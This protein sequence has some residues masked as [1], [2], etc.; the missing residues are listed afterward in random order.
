M[1]ENFNAPSIESL[2]SIFNRLQKIISQLVIL[3]EN[4]SQEYLNMKSLRSLPSEWNTHVIVWRNKTDLDIMSIDDL[5]NNFKIVKQE[6]KRTVVSSSSSGSL[7]MAFL[8]S[9]SSTNEV[10]TASIQVSGVSTP[11]SIV[12]LEQIHEDDLEVMDLKWQLTLLSMRARRSFQ[13]TGKEIIINGSD[14]AGYDKTKV[15]CF[16]CH[17]MGHFAREC[18]SPR[19]QES[20]PGNQDNL[21]KTVNVEDTSSKAMVAIDGA[22]FNKFEFD[23]ATYKR[24]LASVEEQLAFYKKN[25]VVF[26]DQIDVLKRD[27]SFRD[28]EITVLNLQKEKLKNEKESN[29][30]KINNFKNASKSLDKLIG[31]QITDNSRTELGFTSYTIVAP[32]PT[33][34][35]AP[36]SIYLSNSGLEEFQHPE[37]KGYGPKDSK[38]VYVD[39]SNE[40]KKVPDAPIIKDWNFAPTAVLTKSG[41]VPISTARQS[42]S[43]TAAP[44]SDARPINT[45]ASKHLGN[46]APQDALKDQGYFDSGCSRH[47]TV[48]KDETSRILKG[49]ITDIE[50]QVEKT[51]QQNGV[52][53]RRN[54]TQIEAPRTMLA[55][56]KLPTTF[57]AEAVNTA[58]YVQNR[59]L[60]VKPHFKTPYELFKGRSPALSFMRPFEC[61][62]S[63]LNTLDQLGKFDG[64][65]DEGI[66]VGYSTT[67]KAFR[68]YIIRTIKVEE[69]L[70]ITFLENKP[71]IAGGG[72]EWL[73]D[74]DALSKS[75]NYAPVSA[76]TNYNDFSASD[77]HNKDKHGSS[78]ASK[79]DN[80]ERPNDESSTKTVNTAGPVNN[81]TP[82]YVDY[83]NDHLMPDLE[84]ARIFDDAYDDRDE[85]KKDNYNNLE[86][87]ISVSPIPSTR[88]HKDHPKEHIIEE[89]SQIKCTRWKKLY[90]V[91]IKLLE[92][93]MRLYPPTYWIM[94]SKE[95][96]LADQQKDGIFLSREKY[97]SDILKKFSFSSIKSAS[98]PMETHKPLS[99]D[100]AGTDVDVHLYR[101]MIGLLMYLTS[102]R[103]D[104]MFA[105]PKDLPLELIAYSDSDYAGAS[106]DRKSTTGGLKLKGYLINDGYADLVQHADKKELAIPGQTITGKELSN[107]LMAGSLPKTN[108]QLCWKK[109][110][111]TEASIRHDLKLNDAECT[112]CLLVKDIKER[113]KNQ[114]QNQ[115]KSRANE[116]Y[117][118]V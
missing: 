72:P 115:K 38:S 48:T 12:N 54:R 11:V 2:D 71:M 45:A 114:S 84:H 101:S 78:Q 66:F 26:C 24:G 30:I 97:V 32:P 33:G 113:D 83:L 73:F 40:I 104:I 75:M 39:T 86:T 44:V 90:M 85:S 95:G 34:L 21:R 89:S 37:F 111:I 50:N 28:L 35:F 16:N 1:Y 112:S 55:D 43:C 53:E 70:H 8:S 20:R 106:L 110:V 116:K 118:K 107:L 96:E 62:I 74:I 47:M 76:G 29:Q 91:F 60:V 15:E 4:I 56:S 103:P 99:K 5:Y 88:I 80:Q 27:A 59:V 23:L 105:Y 6:V 61:H 52:A 18:R 93:G 19:H 92:P 13:G 3:G 64:K 67:S 36:P 17:K 100:A 68:V 49:F 69:N 57:W 58:C 9:L 65:T 10:D 82:I 7:N 25:E 102:S 42:S 81:A 46:G 117:G 109:V 98:T 87:V 94:D 108:C 14:T 22:E 63:I 77:G 41:I 79:S 31:S 51:P